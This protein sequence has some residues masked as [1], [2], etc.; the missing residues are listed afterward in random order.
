MDPNALAR[1]RYKVAA[2]VPVHLFGNVAHIDE[3]MDAAAGVPVIEDTAQSP[4]SFWRNRLTGTFGVGSFYS[5]AS[6]K[7]IPAGGGGLAAINN[8]ALAVRVRELAAKLDSRGRM[9]S[10][11]RAAMQLAKA[12]LFSRVLYGLI[13]N[14]LRA[15]T[16]ESGY[17]LAS[18]DAR[19]IA[20][21]SAAAVKSLAAVLP[22]RLLRQRQN[23]L[24][25]LARIGRPDG[26]IL[27]VE[28][29]DAR[30]A[31]T[32][33]PVVLTNESERDAVRQAML[34]QGV[35]TSTIHHNCAEVATVHFYN[36]GCLVSENVAR[37]LLTLPNFAGLKESD[38]DRVASV[39][40]TSLKRYRT[41]VRVR[42]TV[43]VKA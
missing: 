6:S 33:F 13:G 27:P 22:Q 30:Y 29:A 31:Y 35:D 26:V 42:C 41:T 20:A 43:E 17:L 8:P 1:L 37:S 9:D 15:A 2:I 14:R 3:I 19:A 39:F 38:L 21:S 23:S 11:R 40:L 10:F 24:Q 34:E 36:G 7:C 4:L 5:F 18:M 32:L 25:L 12:A 28:P 16:E